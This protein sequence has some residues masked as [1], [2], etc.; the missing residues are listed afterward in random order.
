MI[1]GSQYDTDCRDIRNFLAAN[2]IVYEWVDRD[3]EPERVPS[4]MPGEITGPAVVV[5]RKKCLHGPTVREVAEALEL[6]TTPYDEHYDVAVVGAGPAG[7]AAGV[8][9]ASEGLKVL[10]VERSAA[11]GQAGTSSR[12]ENYLG[13]PHGISG[14]DLSGRAL[15]QARN[16]G[17]QIAMTRS[18][19][20]IARLS[21]GYCVQLDEG[22]RVSA[23]VVVLATGVEWRRLQVEGIDRLHGRGVLYGAGRTEANSVIG[24]RVYVVGGGNSAGQ[25][26]V[27]FA[28]Y[29]ADVKVL[30]RGQGLTLTMSSYLI[31]QIASKGNVEVIPYTEVIAAEGDDTLERIRVQQRSPDGSVEPRLETWDAD[32]LF[33]MIGADANTS[34]L[35]RELECDGH[36]YIC[37]GRDLTQ[38]TLEREAFPL[39]TS[40]PGIF[41]VGDVRH[42]SIKR[43]S[44]GVGEGSMSISFIHQ[45][46]TLPESQRRAD[47]QESSA[48]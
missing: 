6:Q 1:V 44:S 32:A 15:Q 14:D 27:F 45:Y 22:D 35:P 38:W 12:I 5:D 37:T 8:Y 39:E 17:A 10:L 19:Q 24:K 3:R 25:A 33:L 23:D 2:R 30:V 9:G 48:I 16:F 46:L 34:W 47:L 40:M 28:N 11:G 42:G 13:F 31:Q 43:V 26:A 41:A 21:K 7:M 4:C 36:G 18:V 20:S 29:A